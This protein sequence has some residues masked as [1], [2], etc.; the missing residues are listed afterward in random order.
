[1]YNKEDQPRNKG[2]FR[3]KLP[4]GKVVAFKSQEELDEFYAFYS[5]TRFK[6]S[7]M[8]DKINTFLNR[9]RKGYVTN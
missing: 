5:R 2:P 7:E 4:N 1:M 3:R 9:L 8:Y 6:P